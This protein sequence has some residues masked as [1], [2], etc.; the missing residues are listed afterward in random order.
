MRLG[1]KNMRGH[2]KSLKVCTHHEDEVCAPCNV[3]YKGITS[4]WKSI[5]VQ[6]NIMMSGTKKNVYMESALIVE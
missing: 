4:L 5:I 2:H 3:L 6:K 1:L